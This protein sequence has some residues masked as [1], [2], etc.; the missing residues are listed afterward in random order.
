MR[1]YEWDSSERKFTP[2]WAADDLPPGDR[3]LLASLEVSKGDYLNGA[4][5]TS[6]RL[7]CLL[8][9]AWRMK[10]AGGELVVRRNEAIRI[11][12]GFGHSVE[13]IQDSFALQMVKA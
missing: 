3:V 10:I 13:A 8:K 9:G 5:A 7:I 1:L 2:R 4:P 12:A 11:P 6:E